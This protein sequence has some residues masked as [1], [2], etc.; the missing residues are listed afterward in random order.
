MSL[1]PTDVKKTRVKGQEV[2]LWCNRIGGVSAAPGRE[3]NP[4]PVQRVRGSG[5]AAAA[6]Q[7]VTMAGI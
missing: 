1:H 2:P 7:V 6:A 4:G 3:F 5:A